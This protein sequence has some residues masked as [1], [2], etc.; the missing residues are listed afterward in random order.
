MSSK[1]GKSSKAGRNK[2]RC[3]YYKLVR[4]REQN[5]HL[6]RHPDDDCADLAARLCR[7]VL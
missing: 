3:A 7:A 1:Q 2:V 4:R 6:V 5:K